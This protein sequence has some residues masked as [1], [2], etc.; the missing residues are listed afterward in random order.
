VERVFWKQ[1]MVL[2]CMM[3]LLPQMTGDYKLNH[4]YLPLMLFIASQKLT[5][6]DLIYAVLFGL[7]LIPKAYYWINHKPGLHLVPLGTVLNPIFMTSILVL[8]VIQGFSALRAP[9]EPAAASG[10]LRPA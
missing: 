9:E 2:T 6:H 7:L 8:I 1:V 5:R 3:L 10:A 4:L